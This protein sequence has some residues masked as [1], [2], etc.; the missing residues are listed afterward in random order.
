[1]SKIYYEC[2]QNE[3]LAVRLLIYSIL[4]LV[5][6]TNKYIYIYIPSKAILLVIMEN[7]KL[8]YYVKYGIVILNIVEITI[9]GE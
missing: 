4:L 9:F 3:I 1:L 2:E 7:L 5:K 6:S 8:L